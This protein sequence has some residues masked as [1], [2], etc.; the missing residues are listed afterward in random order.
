MTNSDCIF[1]K[2]I[3]KEIPAKIIKENEHVLVIEDIAPKAPVHYLILPKKHIVNI[4]YLT[5]QD[6]QVV[7]HLFK[8]AQEL[9]K[10][11]PESNAQ[12]APSFNLISNNGADASQSVFHLHMH[13]IAGKNIKDVIKELE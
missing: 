13:F 4:N 7:W 6:D 2:I 12:G 11:L 1:C 10:D 5:E 3:K 9:A 8:M